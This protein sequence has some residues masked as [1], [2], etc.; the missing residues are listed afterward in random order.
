VVKMTKVLKSSADITKMMNQMM[1]IKEMQ[2]SLKDMQRE[3]VK[4]KN[5]F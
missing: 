5:I 1:P 3:M 4:V 2:Q